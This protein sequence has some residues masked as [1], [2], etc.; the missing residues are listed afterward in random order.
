M[1]SKEIYYSKSV[2]STRQVLGFHGGSLL[3]T[4]S[5]HICTFHLDLFGG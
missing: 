5:T 2:E 1:D 3:T 4:W